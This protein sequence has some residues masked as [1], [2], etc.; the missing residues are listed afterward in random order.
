MRTEVSRR[1]VLRTLAGLP[2]LVA[3][4]AAAGTREDFAPPSPVTPG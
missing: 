4:G 2:M 3:A 1:A